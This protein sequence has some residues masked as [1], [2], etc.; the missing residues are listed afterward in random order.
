MG[1]SPVN[2]LAKAQQESHTFSSRMPR[3]LHTARHIRLHRLLV[4][5]NVREP[6]MRKTCQDPIEAKLKVKNGCLRH[7]SVKS[8]YPIP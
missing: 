4:L 8:R 2:I 1:G 3:I 5:Q 7:P 6:E